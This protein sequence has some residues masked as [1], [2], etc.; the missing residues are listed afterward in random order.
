M[1]KCTG[2][3]MM[4][5]EKNF[6]FHYSLDLIEILKKLN[7]FPIEVNAGYLFVFNY[8]ATF[9]HELSIKVD[10]INN[11]SHYFSKRKC[12]RMFFFQS[13][14]IS[15][16]SGQYQKKTV[17]DTKIWIYIPAIITL[18]SCF[19]FPAS[20]RTKEVSLNSRFPSYRIHWWRPQKE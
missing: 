12:S 1:W 7:W 3:K 5:T 20:I 16:F 18:F 10:E 14:E 2:W 13:Y 9:S 8:F 15:S 11:F 6:Q 17:V 19:P 4:R